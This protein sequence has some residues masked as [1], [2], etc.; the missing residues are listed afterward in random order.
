MR[1]S[2]VQSVRVL[3]YMPL[4]ACYTI[5]RERFPRRNFKLQHSATFRTPNTIFCHKRITTL[6]PIH[7]FTF[8]PHGTKTPAGTYKPHREDQ[9]QNRPRL[10]LR[11][12]S[13]V[14]FLLHINTP[15]IIAGAETL[16]DKMDAS[17]NQQSVHHQPSPVRQAQQR[18]TASMFRPSQRDQLRRLPKLQRQMATP[19]EDG[20]DEIPRSSLRPGSRQ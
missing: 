2:R 12:S 15:I 5:H 20:R 7:H 14:H 9:F 3:P 11:L 19:K 8:L 4:L 10:H 18:R 13:N 6:I 1:N 17:Q 16:D